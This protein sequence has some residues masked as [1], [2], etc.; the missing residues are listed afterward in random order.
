[1]LKQFIKAETLTLSIFLVGTFIFGI[2][3]SYFGF[4]VSGIFKSKP[5]PTPNSFVIAIPKAI[6]KNNPKEGIYNVLLLG[7]G[8]AGHEGSLLTDSMIVLHVDTNAK[9]ATMISIP[10]DL[11][12][13]GNHK[14]N[15]AGIAGFENIGPVI[16]NVTGLPINYYVS[17]DFGGFIKLI[18][19]LGGIKVNV[20]NSFDDPFYPITGEENNTCGLTD[21]EIFEL[22]NKYQGF[23]LERQFTC[24]YEH[25]HFEKGPT[26][27]DGKTALKFV[28]SRHGDSDFGRSL[29]QFAILTGIGNKLIN[30]KSLNKIDQTVNTLFGIVKT[31]LDLGTIKSLSEV[32]NDPNLYKINQIQLSTN[33]VLNEGFAGDG[34]YILS[35]KS[36]GFNFQSIKDYINSNL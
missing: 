30:L 5:T 25:L 8:G 2:A 22:K 23:E 7:Y 33:N 3:I 4:N 19:N 34:E 31:D 12:V 20:P 13:P 32:F 9:K 1:M 36:G 15:A 21:P 17:V 24:R 27:I 28:R 14:I 26:D 6:N 11:W 29:R 10:R 18:D 16:Q 35:P